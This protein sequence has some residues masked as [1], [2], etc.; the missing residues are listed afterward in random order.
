[1]RSS[2]VSFNKATYLDPFVVNPGGIKFSGLTSLAFADLHATTHFTWEVLDCS[3]DVPESHL[4]G[5][6]HKPF[7]SELSQSHL[8]FFRGE[9]ELSH[10]LVEWSHDLVESI[11]FYHKMAPNQL[12]TGAQ[13]FFTI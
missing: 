6:C 13:C 5:Q 10:D 7:E 1:M 11:L 12:K 4:S 8:K 9:S 3:S 2:N